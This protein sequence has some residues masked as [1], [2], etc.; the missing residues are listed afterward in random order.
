MSIYLV[1]V[2]EETDFIIQSANLIEIVELKLQVE[3]FTET[4]N[5]SFEL[6]MHVER[7][8]YDCNV[9]ESLPYLSF[10]Q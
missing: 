8:W 1:K 4:L 2:L 3:Y 9:S 10:S 7:S 5:S 6:F